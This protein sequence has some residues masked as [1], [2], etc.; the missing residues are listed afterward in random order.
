V[1]NLLVDVRLGLRARRRRSLFAAIGIA[2][3][4]A[5]LSAATVV[6]DG[7]GGGFDR[8]VG[9]ADLPDVIARFNPQDPGRVASRIGALPDL[10]AFTLRREA[11][12]APIRSGEHASTHASVELVGAGRRGYGIVAGHGLTGRAGEVLVELGLARAW[13]VGLGSSL[14]LGDLP[15]EHVVGLAQSPDDVSYPL[16]VP[17]IYVSR[18]GLQAQVGRR[19]D[20]QVNIA[21]IWLRDPRHLNEV[22][23]QARASSYGIRGLRFV[24]RASVHVLLDQAAGIVIDLLVALSVIALATAA[25]MLA[26]SARAEVQRHLVAIGV[27]RTVGESRRRATLV[28]ALVVLGFAG[29]AAVL[30]S[31]AGTLATLGSSSSLLTLLN[32]PAPG[33][34]LILPLLAALLATIAIPVLATAWPVWRLTAADPV[35]LLSGAELRNASPQ[36]RRARRGGLVRLGTRLVTDRRIRFVST[37]VT[38]AGSVA[39]I[40]LML[41]LASALSALENNPAALGKHY[42]LTAQLPASAVRRVAAI[43]GVQAAAARYELQAVDSFNLGETIDVVA[44]S[45]SPAAFE[46]PPLTSGHRIRNDR[47]AEVGAGLAGALG[48]QPG[49]TLAIELPSGKELRLTVAGIVGSLGHDGRVAFV[50]AAPLL[51][52]D[53][54]AP[55]QVAV[56]LAPGAGEPA[57][58]TAIGAPSAAAGTLTSGGAPLVAVLRAIL[59]A[60]GI[61][62]GL[63]CLYALIQACTLTV[64]ERRRTVAVMQA[65]GAGP[66]AVMRLLAGAAGILLLPAAV[67]GILLQRLLLGPAL[68]RLAAS[69]ATLP[70]NPS[71]VEVAVVLAGLAVAGTL[72]VAWV[73][74]QAIGQDVVRGLGAS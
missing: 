51:R 54:G 42:A 33:A 58:A 5:M 1:R 70:L 56:V 64:Q 68:S 45:R 26:A 38:L 7:L 62:D 44:Y 71:L 60:V 9:Q 11:T 63:V 2:L 67:L 10:A 47:Q 12:N 30:G 32:E 40:L 35:E 18:S 69:Y 25:V 16:A 29:P 41:A 24:T 43:R 34:G 49:G 6:A 22:L 73:S 27:R 37:S 19:L 21:E 65:L 61:V 50:P 20:P 53:P 52:A 59:L 55:E 13:H 3:A 14:E 74:H 4:A 48:V 31:L 57:V 23:V 46:S 72:T 28:H 15:P 66:A 36:R 8:A 39:F 17:R